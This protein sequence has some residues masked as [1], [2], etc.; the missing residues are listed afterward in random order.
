MNIYSI[1]PDDELFSGLREW[2]QNNPLSPED[3]NNRAPPSAFVPILFGADNGFYGKKHTPEQIKSWSDMRLG[4]KNPNYG[5]K[6]WTEESLKKLRQPKKN[7]ENYKG[8]P[9]KIC[10]INKLG[11]AIQITTEIYNKQ[12]DFNL[13]MEQWEYVTTTSKVAKIRRQR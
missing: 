13:P 6:A 9:G 4:D 3:L 1:Q 11:E 2:C 7:K 8:S 10:V 12:K 5:G